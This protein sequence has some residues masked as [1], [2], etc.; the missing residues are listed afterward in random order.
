M[1]TPNLL[2]DYGQ[3]T[4]QHV[5]HVS[6]PRLTWRLIAAGSQADVWLVE[7]YRVRLIWPDITL[8]PSRV[9]QW[10]VTSS[11]CLEVDWMRMGRIQVPLFKGRVSEHAFWA[12]A[13][14]WHVLD[15]PGHLRRRVP[16]FKICDQVCLYLV[17]HNGEIDVPE[18]VT[19]EDLHLTTPD[20]YSNEMFTLLWIDTIAMGRKPL[21]LW[22]PA[23]CY[24]CVATVVAQ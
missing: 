15:D 7:D 22:Q 18:E 5:A 20:Y 2:I 6:G 9:T 1:D 23:H 10:H 12:D 8:L 19:G 16:C 17:W 21:W 24:Y 13:L 4:Q 3:V 14:L 11:V